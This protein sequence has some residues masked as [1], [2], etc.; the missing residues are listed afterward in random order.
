MHTTI[1]STL[2]VSCAVALGVLGVA[3]GAAAPA[4]ADD[5][6]DK[7]I[8]NIEWVNANGGT[9]PGHHEGWVRF[10][11]KLCLDM[12]ATMADGYSFD[13]VSEMQMTLMTNGGWSR[14]DAAAF[15]T[16]AYFDICPELIPPDYK[17]EN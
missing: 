14:L 7:F 3:T 15:S 10:G 4:R 12:R 5:R 9:I 8:K 17:E 13:E 16:H 1:T 11:N 2:Q 6:E